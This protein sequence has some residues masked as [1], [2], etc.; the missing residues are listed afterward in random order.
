MK[1]LAL[2]ILLAM[3]LT[4]CISANE[5][6]VQESRKHLEVIGDGNL[7]Y[8][9]MFNNNSE[10]IDRQVEGEFSL[11][12]TE[13]GARNIWSPD[14]DVK[15]VYVRCQPPELFFITLYGVKK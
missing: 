4:G 3:L 9:I 13:C 11:Q 6:L 2:I 1:K 8:L 15:R 12:A 5:R 7:D 10:V 14:Y